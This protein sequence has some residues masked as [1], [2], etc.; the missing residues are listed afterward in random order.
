M[1][2]V[3]NCYSIFLVAREWAQWLHES[4]VDSVLIV[5]SL[6]SVSDALDALEMLVLV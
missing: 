3:L 5:G 6:M 2:F 1:N 4:T